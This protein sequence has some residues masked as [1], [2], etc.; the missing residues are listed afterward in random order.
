MPPTIKRNK[1]K[2]KG[3]SA[4]VGVGLAK[5]AFKAAIRS[6]TGKEKKNR[7][8]KLNIEAKIKK[9]SDLFSEL[10]TIV[11]DNR[12]NPLKSRYNINIGQFIFYADHKEFGLLFDEV[13]NQDLKKIIISN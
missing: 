8:I 2:K 9:N 13:K 12:T 6:I 10:T 1:A 4:K 3:K 5:T 11:R 7:I